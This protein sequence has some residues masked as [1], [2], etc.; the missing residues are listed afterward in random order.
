MGVGTLVY[1]GPNFELIPGMRLANVRDGLE[2]Y[3]Y[4]V[5]LRT[6]AQELKA[7]GPSQQLEP[8]DPAL[9]IGDDLVSS[10]FVWTK[11]PALLDAKRAQLAGLIRSVRAQLERSTNAARSTGNP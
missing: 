8:L 2:D 3:E 9:T 7:T 6:L 10:V 5:L 11:D 4:F 1:P